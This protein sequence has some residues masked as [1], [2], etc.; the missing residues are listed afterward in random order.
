MGGGNCCDVCKV[1]DMC[2]SSEL[3][4]NEAFYKALEEEG[5]SRDTMACNPEIKNSVARHH[6]VGRTLP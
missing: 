5:I 3:D 6:S 4:D 2:I 1:F